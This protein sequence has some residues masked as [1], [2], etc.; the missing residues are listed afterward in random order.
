MFMIQS[1]GQGIKRIKLCAT[2]VGLEQEDN[3]TRFLGVYMKHDPKTGFFNMTQ[4]DLIKET[5]GLKVGPA[6][7]DFAPTKAKSVTA[8]RTYL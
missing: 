2:G 8:W 5:L 6:N 4:E 1:S 7:V 3:A